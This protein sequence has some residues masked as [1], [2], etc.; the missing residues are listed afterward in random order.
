M[1][2]FNVKRFF[3]LYSQMSKQECKSFL[4]TLHDLHIINIECY[5]YSEAPGI[6]HIFFYFDGEKDAIPYFMLEK[7]TLLQIQ[8]LLD[9]FCGVN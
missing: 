5:T 6:K 4:C 9:D 1:K 8:E 2:E 3:E 7:E